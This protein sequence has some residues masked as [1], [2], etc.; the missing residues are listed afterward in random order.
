MFSKPLNKQKRKE[1]TIVAYLMGD[2]DT[3]VSKVFPDDKQTITRLEPR[4]YRIVCKGERTMG[5]VAM[6]CLELLSRNKDLR[7]S[8]YQIIDD[9]PMDNSDIPTINMV[10]IP[11][12][13]P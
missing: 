11:R 7:F 8:S 13:K 4:Y 5:T 1:F 12:P 6:E 2:T 3:F 9:L 10:D